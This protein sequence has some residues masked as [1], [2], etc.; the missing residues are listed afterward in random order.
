VGRYGE[1]RRVLLPGG[2]PAGSLAASCAARHLRQLGRHEAAEELD[3]AALATA[4]TPE[5]RADAVVGLVADAVGQLDLATARRR[6]AGA[7]AELDDH[8]PWRPTVRL[9][10]VRAE[11]ALLGDDPTVA[12]GCARSALRL[13]RE[14]R[15]WRHAVKSGLVLGAS[16]DA[17]G[18]RRAA[19]R[20]LG[21]VAAQADRLGLIP[22]VWPA[23]TIR[24]RVLAPRAPVL[25]ARERQQA[26]SAESIIEAAADGLISR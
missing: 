23:R 22:L 17:A 3:R 10:W 21:G 25:A 18:H 15:A 1:A 5:E 14:V 12:V 2:E 16:L 7:V 24:A 4:T 19:V 11:T 26:R 9:A 13:S 6:L 8:S 20:V